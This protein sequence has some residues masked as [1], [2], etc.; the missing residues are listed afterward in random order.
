MLGS[1]AAAAV[2]ALGCIVTYRQAQQRTAEQ[3]FSHV[4]TQRGL[5]S[6]AKE[7]G[8]GEECLMHW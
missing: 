6:T 3:L 1:L 8:R 5:L 4:W 2:A 7:R